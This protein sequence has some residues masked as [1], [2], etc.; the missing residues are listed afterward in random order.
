MNNNAV[1]CLQEVC[2]TYS[3]ALHAFF[4]QR[5]Y[6]F[7]TAPYGRKFNGYMGVGIAVPV[8]LY[9]ILS[10]DITRIADNLQVPSKNN[11]KSKQGIVDA[12]FSQNF[13][14]FW[15]SNNM[16]ENKVPFLMSFHTQLVDLLR[17][18]DDIWKQS[19]DKQ[20]QMISLRL[21]EKTLKLSVFLRFNLPYAMLISYS[22]ADGGAFV[23]CQHNMHM[24][25]LALTRIFS[26][27]IST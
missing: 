21:R 8:N 18:R 4:S 24:N 14:L 22:E 7:I 12:H 5:G 15:S 1:I 10:V 16:W 9:D 19:A 20:N 26:L 6:H 3:G 11:S 25:L 27:V 23:R 2:S 13:G 17:S